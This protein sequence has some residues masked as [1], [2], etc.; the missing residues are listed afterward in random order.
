MFSGKRFTRTKIVKRDQAL[1]F[2]VAY[3][4]FA[5]ESNLLSSLY[6]RTLRYF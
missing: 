4:T 6:L 2:D 5:D 1:P 3:K